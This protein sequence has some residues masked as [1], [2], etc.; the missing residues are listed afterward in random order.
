MCSSVLSPTDF[1]EQF[2]LTVDASD[3]GIGAA[4]QQHSHNVD[5][6]V[7]NFLQET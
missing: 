3:V 6:V 2:K 5:R 4:F 1:S 7:S